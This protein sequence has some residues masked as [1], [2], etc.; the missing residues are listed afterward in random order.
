MYS[1][2][3]LGTRASADQHH[4]TGQFQPGPRWSA[5]QPLW[6]EVC[7]DCGEPCDQPGLVSRCKDRH[8][9]VSHCKEETNM[10]TKISTDLHGRAL[11][12]EPSTS[13]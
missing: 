6:A 10:T 12:A 2:Q 9:Q 7:S 8:Q 5:V 4:Y 3:W 11:A 1:P 13:D